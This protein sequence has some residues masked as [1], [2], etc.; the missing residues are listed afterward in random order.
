MVGYVMELVIAGHAPEGMLCPALISGSP[1]PTVDCKLL[2]RCDM[3]FLHTQNAFGIRM[4]SGFGFG[5]DVDFGFPFRQRLSP[6]L[7]FVDAI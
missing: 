7:R 3:L 6:Y 1:F 4:D 5:F 2:A